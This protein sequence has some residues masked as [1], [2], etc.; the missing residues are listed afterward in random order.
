MKLLIVGFLLVSVYAADHLGSEPR[1]T[2][3]AQNSNSW[4]LRLYL[5]LLA[6]R[7]YTDPPTPAQRIVSTRIWL[8]KEFA[9][10]LGD[11][12]EPTLAGRIDRVDGK[13]VAKELWG[14]FRSSKNWCRRELNWT[15]PLIQPWELFP[16]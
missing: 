1:K 2:D 12:P 14:K 15:H 4:D 16:A 8:S 9:V 11:E 13:F 7:Y 6:P 10:M 3:T 5:H